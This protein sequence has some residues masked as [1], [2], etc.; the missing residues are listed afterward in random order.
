MSVAL[1]TTIV[2]F[3]LLQKIRSE[4]Y[5]FV[6]SKHIF[7]KTIY[8]IDRECFN[9]LC[10]NAIFEETV[11]KGHEIF[12]TGDEGKGMYFLYH[13]KLAYAYL[14]DDV[15]YDPTSSE[16]LANSAMTSCF[17]ASNS[18]ISEERYASPPKKKDLTEGCSDVAELAPPWTSRGR[19]H[20]HRSALRFSGALP[21]GRSVDR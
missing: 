6:L 13:G 19:S 21:R 18:F 5:I 10:N 1:A 3:V 2:D 9:K 16:D 8:D 20:R 4:A 15:S 7:Y 11:D 12:S 17:V 14:L